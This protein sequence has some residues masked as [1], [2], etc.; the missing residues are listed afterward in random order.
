MALVTARIPTAVG[1]KLALGSGRRT[2]TYRDALGRRFDCVVIGPGSGSG[3][4]LQDPDKNTIFD[5][6]AKATTLQQTN[7]YHTRLP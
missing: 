1:K 7:V 4:K 2:V 6:V 3:A 5:N